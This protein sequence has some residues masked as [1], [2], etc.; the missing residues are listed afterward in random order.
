MRGNLR[1][2][3]WEG[4]LTSGRKKKPHASVRGVG[5]F[6]YGPSFFGRLVQRLAAGA[7]TSAVTAVVVAVVRFAP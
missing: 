7:V 3:S 2:E 6:L 1:L 5:L 4:D